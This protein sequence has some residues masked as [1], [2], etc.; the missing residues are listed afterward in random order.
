M[1]LIK[2]ELFNLVIDENFRNY[3]VIQEER[4]NEVCCILENTHS[5]M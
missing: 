3:F 5:A 2:F 1:S 4:L